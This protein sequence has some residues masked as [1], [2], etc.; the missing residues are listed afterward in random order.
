MGFFSSGHHLPSRIHLRSFN[1]TL[2]LMPRSLKNTRHHKKKRR[3][4]KENLGV[5]SDTSL[6]LLQRL[7]GPAQQVL[8]SD[9][10]YEEMCFPV[11]VTN[12]AHPLR[13][14]SHIC[15]LKFQI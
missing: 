2:A 15:D 14:K 1:Q 6:P 7:L 3:E 13:T 8:D 9:E 12:D 10:V 4:S 5:S 11:C